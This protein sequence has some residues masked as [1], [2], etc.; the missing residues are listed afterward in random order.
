M[1]HFAIAALIGFLPQFAVADDVAMVRYFTQADRSE[2]D[3]QGAGVTERTPFAIASVGKTLTA[4]AVLRLVDRGALRLDDKVRDI[5]AP[6]V[7]DGL[8]GIDG[9]TVRHLLAMTSGL[10]DYLNDEYIDDALANPADVQNPRIA[11]QYAAGEPALFAPGTSFDYSNT[12][13]VLAGLILESVTG[14][15][16]AQVITGEVLQP[17]NMTGSFVFGSTA[18]PATFPTGHEGRQHIRSYYNHAGFGDGGVIAPATDVAQF[19]QALFMDRTLLSANAMR[20][21]TQDMS[22]QGYGL[23]IEMDGDIFGH[24]GG[25]LGFSSDARIDITTGEVAVI[26]IARSDGDTDWAFD[27]LAD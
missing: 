10:A 27:Q 3:A 4:V 14:Q 25:D 12:N 7:L 20:A 6:D 19:Y 24:S 26:L 16:Y 15:T 8:N 2:T 23:G 1:R 18:L 22:G 11:V 17:A 9:V 21:L 5:L 13:Y